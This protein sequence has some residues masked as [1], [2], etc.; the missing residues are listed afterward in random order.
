MREEISGNKV[1]TFLCGN[2]ECN[3]DKGNRKCV[4]IGSVMDSNNDLREVF[5]MMKK[6]VETTSDHADWRW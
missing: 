5:Q 1:R 6:R 3:V 2:D 4:N